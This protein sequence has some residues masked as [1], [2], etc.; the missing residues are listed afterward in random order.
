MEETFESG[1]KSDVTIRNTGNIDAYI[2]A[3]VIINFVSDDGKV[4][5]AAPQEGTDYVIVWSSHG[6][7]KGSDGY[8]YHKKRLPMTT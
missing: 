8:W 3:A 4:L 5:A 7:V 2:R 1:V 6:W